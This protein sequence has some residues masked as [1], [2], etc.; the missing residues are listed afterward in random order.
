MNTK[1]DASQS[2]SAVEAFSFAEEIKNLINLDISYR[3]TFTEVIK[4]KKKKYPK[5][6][7]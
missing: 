3:I 4:K 7:M 2:N 1:L 6:P 5:I